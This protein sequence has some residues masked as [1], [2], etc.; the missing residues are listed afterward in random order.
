MTIDNRVSKISHNQSVT[1]YYYLDSQLESFPAVTLSSIVKQ[2]ENKVE[3]N[4][5]LACIFKYQST[6]CQG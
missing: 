6:K 1:P 5:R 2:S 4:W 3:E